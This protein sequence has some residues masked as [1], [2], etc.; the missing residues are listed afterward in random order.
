MINQSPLKTS[1]LLA[2]PPSPHHNVTEEEEARVKGWRVVLLFGSIYGSKLVIMEKH[3]DVEVRVGVGV[4]ET[5]R[6]ES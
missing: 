2:A 3:T 4:R 5:G 1:I 6:Q